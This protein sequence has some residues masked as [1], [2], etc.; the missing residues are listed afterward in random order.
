MYID[1]LNG[2][3]IIIISYY[4]AI[5]YKYD[6][7]L[8]KFFKK[9]LDNR[10][11]GSKIVV[12]WNFKNLIANTYVTTN[13]HFT[14]FLF[15]LNWNIVN[16]AA[17]MHFSIVI[18]HSNINLHLIYDP[19]F[20]GYFMPQIAIASQFYQ[21]GRYSS[22]ITIIQNNNLVLINLLFDDYFLKKN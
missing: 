11:S 4:R 21:T 13:L 6:K 18:A 16:H 5:K 14:I 12:K 17:K 1:Q 19:L 22:N 7:L 3:Y 15:F 9:R 2:G 10:A 8:G 20:I